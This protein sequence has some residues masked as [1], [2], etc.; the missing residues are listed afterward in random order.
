MCKNKSKEDIQ[1]GYAAVMLSLAHKGYIELDK[2][3]YRHGWDSNNVK[4]IVKYNQVQP[5]A[6]GKA[7]LK[8]L[9]PTEEQY[10]NLILRHTY[11][12]EIAL[13][14]FQKKVA[15]DYQNKNSFVRNIKNAITNIGISQ[16]YFQKAEY[17]Q[18][19]QQA[20]K[21]VRTLAIIGI[22]LI[23]AGNL[24]S[25]Q[26]RLDLAF[27]AFFVLGI[28]FIAG[29]ICLDRRSRKY[30]L[31]TQFGEDEYAK[32]RGLYNYLNSEA[33]MSERTVVE[34]PLW[35]NYLIYATAFGISKKVI[36]ALKVRCDETNL[37]A[38]PVL[39]NPY[40]RSRTFHHSGRS[41]RRS[42]RSASFT[43]RSGGGHGG[44]GGGGRGGGGG[45]GGH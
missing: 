40:H 11:G 33:L 4:I 18:P 34:L 14:L 19:K 29:A 41:F 26:T 10:F 13:S 21:W 20:R 16:G 37:K 38:S 42:T 3:N 32:W 28:D 12:L 9:T 15:Q 5:R 17:K 36:K 2:I 39:R 27:G 8:P 44:F 31:L 35:E 6:E 25:Y 45:G 24:I 1:D 7:D 22:L 43:A 30:V 23:I